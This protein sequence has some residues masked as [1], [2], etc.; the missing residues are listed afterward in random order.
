MSIY[1]L[2]TDTMTDQEL[3]EQL[4]PHL[5]GHAFELQLQYDQTDDGAY[6]QTM[7]EFRQLATEYLTRNGVPWGTFEER[8]GR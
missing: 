2:N 6:Y 5:L 7:V 4:M 1:D 8:M 3:A